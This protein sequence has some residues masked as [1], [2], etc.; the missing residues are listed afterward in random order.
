VRRHDPLQ[1]DH[2]RRGIDLFATVKCRS[3]SFAGITSQTVDTAATN[4]ARQAIR[5][6]AT[7]KDRAERLLDEA[8]AMIRDLQ[9]KLG[10]ERLA[11][12]EALETVQRLETEMRVAARAQE[13]SAAELAAEL[14]AGPARGRGCACGGAGSPPGGRGA[15]AGYDYRPGDAAGSRG[16][17]EF[18]AR[19]HR[20]VG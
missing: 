6:E 2:S 4:A 3:R 13:T 8:Q 20:F 14:L 11:K 17:C 10:H 1:V 12:D 19:G 5:S 9:T 18:P 16:P 7:A 15:V